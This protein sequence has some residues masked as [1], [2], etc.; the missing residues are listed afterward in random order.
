M[1][2]LSRRRSPSTFPRQFWSARASSPDAVSRKPSSRDCSSSI[3]NASDRCCDRC[4]DAFDSSSISQRPGDDPRRYLGVDR[5]LPRSPSDSWPSGRTAGIQRRRD[6]RPRHHR[7]STWVSFCFRSGTDT[8]SLRG[9]P[10]AAS[11]RFTLGRCRGSRIFHRAQGRYRENAGPSDRRLRIESFDPPAHYG[12]GLFPPSES[13]R[14]SRPRPAVNGPLS[15]RAAT[16]G[17]CGASSRHKRRRA[18][19]RIGVRR[20]RHSDGVS[21]R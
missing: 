18:F 8:S 21:R 6:L 2:P 15:A 14:P 16:S 9:V 12:Q 5:I 3:V 20:R 17:P 13:W 10:L 19:P 7:A 4:E 1:C 11:A